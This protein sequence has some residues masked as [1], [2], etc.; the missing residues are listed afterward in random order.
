[1]PVQAVGDEFLTLTDG[2][3]LTWDR[4]LQARVDS[5]WQKPVEQRIETFGLPLYRLKH[6]LQRRNIRG[7]FEIAQ[8]WYQNESQTFAGPEANFLVSRAMMLGR[9]DRGQRQQAIE[10]M[11]RALVLQQSCSRE[12]LVSLPDVAFSKD[13][14]KTGISD[15]LLPVWSSAEQSDKEL[16]RISSEFDLDDLAKKWPGLGVYFSALAIDANQRQRTTNWNSAMGDVPQLRPWQRILGSRFSE[17]PLSI[18]IR[19]TEG[20]TRVSAMYWWATAADQQ[21][22]KSERLLTLLKV[23]ANYGQQY[24]ALSKL[25]LSKAVE[26]TDAEEVRN[27][28][29]ADNALGR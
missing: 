25:A 8:P 7:A 22:A 5:V 13:Q 17:T 10:P 14:F 2:R 6:R 12:F 9:I 4:V 24:P 23:V 18:L 15:D 27:I 28:L 3:K 20:A 19:D 26:L 1:M 16:K 29:Q 11:L 21:A